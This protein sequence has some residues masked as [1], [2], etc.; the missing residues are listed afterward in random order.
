MLYSEGC[1]VSVGKF[2]VKFVT[3][4]IVAA[5][6]VNSVVNDVLYAGVQS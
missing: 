4:A 2:L 6:I 3:V 5:V 1:I